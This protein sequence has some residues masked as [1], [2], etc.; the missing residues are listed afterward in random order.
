MKKTAEVRI[1]LDWKEIISYIIE[2]RTKRLSP[3]LEQ[4]YST[5]S[6]QTN[7]LKWVFSFHMPIT[8][9]V[10]RFNNY[11]SYALMYTYVPTENMKSKGAI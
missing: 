5:P 10:G 7:R 11:C 2:K 4:I 3:G 9:Q 8:K 6:L 1:I